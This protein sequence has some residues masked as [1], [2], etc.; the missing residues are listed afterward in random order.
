MK[1]RGKREIREGK[2]QEEK[3]K[4]GQGGRRKKRGRSDQWFSGTGNRSSESNQ[5][6][7]CKSANEQIVEA[8]TVHEKI[9]A[10]GFFVAMCMILCKVH[11]RRQRL[12]NL[13]ISRL[14]SDAGLQRKSILSCISWVESIL[15]QWRKRCS[16]KMLPNSMK[17]IVVFQ[18]QFML[19]KI[20]IG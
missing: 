16:L 17:E 11:G 14:L 9:S 12:Q 4:R 7:S 18:I 5:S 3:G 20:N 6:R 19:T 10:G 1:R 2:Q 8:A 15:A 13:K